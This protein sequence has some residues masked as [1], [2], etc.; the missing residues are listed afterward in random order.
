MSDL[1]I[2]ECIA[3]ISRGEPVIDTAPDIYHFLASE[4]LEK[5]KVIETDGKA[6]VLDL[7]V[8]SQMYGQ[9]LKGLDVD[10]FAALVDRAMADAGTEFAFGRYGEPRD[11]YHTEMFASGD[12]K[13]AE[14][15]DVHMGI[16]LFCSAGTDVCTPLDG[17]VEIVANNTA[18]LDYG[19]MLVIRHQTENGAPFFI[20]YGHLS[21][22][23]VKSASVG[24]RLSAGDKIAEVGTPPENGNWPPHLHIQVICD[25]LDLAADFPGVACKSQSGMWLSLS[26][27]PAVFFPDVDPQLLNVAA[28]R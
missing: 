16:D 1:Q 7:S 11:L 2:E 9:A 15:R 18:E 8:G 12:D 3:R 10:S 17:V 6:V 26:P 21:L 22:S 28:G 27:N 13:I 5:A 23:S 25:L 14:R 19:P 24:D 20:L 4:D